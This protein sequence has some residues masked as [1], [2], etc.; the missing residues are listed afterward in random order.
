MANL[1]QHVKR[2]TLRPILSQLDFQIKPRIRRRARAEMGNATQQLGANW[3]GIHYSLLP[4]KLVFYGKEILPSD[5]WGQKLCFSAVGWGQP[6][7]AT[8]VSLGVPKLPIKGAFG[9]LE[10][11]NQNLLGCWFHFTARG[12]KKTEQKKQTKTYMFHQ[13]ITS[14]IEIQWYH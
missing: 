4:G 6:Y 10:Q 14:Y 1:H 11:L 12:S 13:N 3:R 2:D 8:M 9:W 7:G 5:W